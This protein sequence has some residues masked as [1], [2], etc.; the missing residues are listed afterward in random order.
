MQGVEPS[1]RRIARNTLMLYLR[2]LLSVV[3]GLYTSRVVL[4]T[5]GVEDYGILGLV[6]GIVS[7]LGFLNFSMEGATSR[8][9]TYDLGLNNVDNLKQTFN[10]AF[11]SHL[12]IAFIVVSFSET[13]G[14]WFINTQLDIPQER[15]FA[16]NCIYQLS[17]LSAVIGITQ[18]PYSAVILAH[19]QMDV[20]AW[21]EILNAILKLFIVW[22]LQLASYDK[23][24]F[25]GVLTFV[26]TV[27]IRSTYRVFCYR[28]YP[29]SH[30]C[31]TWN[32]EILRKML[33]FT[34]WNLYADASVTIRQ[35]GVN[36]LINRFFGLALNAACS[37]AAIVQGTVWTCGYYVL[38]AF[39]PQ[40]TKQYAKR[41]IVLMQQMMSNSLKFTLLFFLLVSVPAI[42]CMPTLMSLWLGKVPQ[43]AII[44]SQILLI[45][46]LFGLINHTFYIGIQSQGDIRKF[47]FVNGTLKLLC[48]P[49]IF[50]L[51]KVAAHPAIPFVFNVVVLILITCW[52][53][54][55]LKGNIPQ[56]DL[57]AL[58]WPVSLVF[59]LGVV[60]L[61]IIL[62]LHLYLKGGLLH[63]S[64]ISLTYFLLLAFGTY[65]L[66]FDK[67]ER[68]ILFQM[69]PWSHRLA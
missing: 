47:C 34:G 48:L 62:P 55:L 6:G 5:L 66:L 64:S 56:L 32:P 38:A 37:I 57:K 21:F 17:I 33:S 54:R 9:I 49:S 69:F 8:F 15:Y 20:Y 25:Y 50:L 44:I 28:H 42:L 36:I 14:L 41:N 67:R 2:T 19:E 26:V 23:L 39:R 10:S 51:L 18:T 27:L 65:Y 11:Q 4:R 16:A 7:I 43:Y 53:L 24:I 45:D 30:L 13:I 46:N 61:F 1:T 22:F 31:L 12:I 40:I 63:L 60:C 35:Q 52:N 58:L 29:E 68:L 59:I 3:V